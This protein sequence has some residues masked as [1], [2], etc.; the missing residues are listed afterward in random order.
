MQTAQMNVTVQAPTTEAT[1]VTTVSTVIS[2][3]QTTVQTEQSMAIT[4][5][6]QSTVEENK[7]DDTSALDSPSAVP[8]V[9]AAKNTGAAGGSSSA[10]I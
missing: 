9:D 4:T 10:I 8:Q 6:E 5:S 3:E 7:F 1:M 2:T